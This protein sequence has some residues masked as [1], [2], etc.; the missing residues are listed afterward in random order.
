MR[1]RDSRSQ[2]RQGRGGTEVKLTGIISA[3][4]TRTQQ[5]AGGSEDEVITI[6]KHSSRWSPQGRTARSWESRGHGPPKTG[7][8]PSGHEP[9]LCPMAA[10]ATNASGARTALSPSSPALPASQAPS[11]WE[12]SQPIRTLPF[13]REPYKLSLHCPEAPHSTFRGLQAPSSWRN[14]FSCPPLSSRIEKRSLPPGMLGAQVQA[15]SHPA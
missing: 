11:P 9:L 12:P 3:V 7:Y 5:G 14:Q 6:K 15:S 2:T 8:H 10:P 1:L 13:K 4:L